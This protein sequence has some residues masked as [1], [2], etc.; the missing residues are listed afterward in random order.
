M[1][2]IHFD[3]NGWRARF[4]GGFNEE[5][6]A[7]V[8]DA[9]GLLWGSEH[10]GATVL[11]GRDAR[12][13]AARF[14]LIMGQVMASYGLRVKVSGGP[15]PTPALG[16]NAAH[17]DGCIGAVMLTAS[18]SSCEHGGILLRGADGGSV[19]SA[20]L[21]ELNR[22]IPA[23]PTY[24]RA[25]VETIDLIT[26]YIRG[27]LSQLDVPALRAANLRVVADPMYGGAMDVMAPLLQ[28]L[29]CRVSMLHA[30]PA[31]DFVGLHP[32][33]QEPWVDKCE[34]QVI[35]TGSDCGIVLDGDGD[36][37]TL[38]DEN[39]RL[40]NRHCL[41]ALLVKHL[42]GRGHEGRVVVTTATSVRATRQ[43]ERLGHPVTVV[44]V[45]FERIY[46]EAREGD[47]L[48]ATEE[49]GGICV[50]DHLMER[51]AIFAC[52]LVLE[53]MAQTGEKL[54]KLVDELDTT[55]G[56]MEYLKRDL[57]LDGA[58]LQ[59]LRNLLPRMNPAEVAGMRPVLVSHLDGLRLQ[60]EDGSWVLLRV[61]RIQPVAR[62]Y[63]EAP[64]H[65]ECE[66]LLKEACAF[67]GA[68]S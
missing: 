9:L 15:C 23:Q 60:F 51:D 30:E 3:A 31:M 13:G 7:R 18:E 49:Y 61:S 2:I 48:V 63:A 24:D 1:G 66:R 64:R 37:G 10:P 53:H 42:S 35:D 54:S 33:P 45:G 5:N 16:W 58:V 32:T 11:I 34:R 36:R 29:G 25:P 28:E 8:A 55:L 4:D 6:V 38:I 59:R 44:P 47:V 40:V 27:L 68:T 26:P 41:M 12:F 46:D 50:P 43:A 39:G 22:T 67:A 14:S 19:G 65:R 21:A 52:L 57:R 17:D 62:A 56:H 20:F